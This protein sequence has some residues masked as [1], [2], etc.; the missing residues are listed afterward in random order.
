MKHIRRRRLMGRLRAAVLLN[1]WFKKA[2]ITVAAREAEAGPSQPP[3]T[4]MKDEEDI[5]SKPHVPICLAAGKGLATL[6]QVMQ[7][8]Q[9]TRRLS[10]VSST[11]TVETDVSEENQTEVNPDDDGTCLSD[12]EL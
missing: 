4:D 12:I 2:P 7:S 9:D 6:V 8:E 3:T 10:R 11:L 5:T 1:S